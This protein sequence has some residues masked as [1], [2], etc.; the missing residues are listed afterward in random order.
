MARSSGLN[1]P[2]LPHNTTRSLADDPAWSS[3]KHANGS[4]PAKT[5]KRNHIINA[6]FEAGRSI[7]KLAADYNLSEQQIMR[8]VKV[9]K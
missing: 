3:P 2:H 8:I 9:R 6:R 1:P 4:N 7:E 5:D